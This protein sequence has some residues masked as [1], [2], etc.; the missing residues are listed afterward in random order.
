MRSLCQP[1]GYVIDFLLILKCFCFFKGTTGVA[2]ADVAGIDDVV[3]ELQ[4][5]LIT[6]SLN[7]ASVSYWSISVSS[8]D[9]P[10][11]LIV[12]WLLLSQCQ[13]PFFSWLVT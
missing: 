4:E 5:V 3:K 9:D 1:F 10:G 12:I 13:L 6:A 8:F 11:C 7:V 2:F